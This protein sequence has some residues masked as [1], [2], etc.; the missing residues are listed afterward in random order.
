MSKSDAK[1]SLKKN[2]QDAIDI[3]NNRP[4]KSLNNKSPTSFASKLTAHISPWEKITGKSEFNYE[5]NKNAIDKEMSKFQ[6]KFPILGKVNKN[7][8]CFSLHI[9]GT[10]K[11]STKRGAFQKSS[12]A[13]EFTQVLNWYS[14]KVRTCTQFFS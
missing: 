3:F 12:T 9:L 14:G 11:I 5:A 7:R 13:E 1:F 10:V 4:S 8:F 6:K 2:I